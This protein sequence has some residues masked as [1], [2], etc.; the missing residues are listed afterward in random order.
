MVN[1]L[2]APNNRDGDSRELFFRKK[3]AMVFNLF[4]CCETFIIPIY[5]D[6]DFMKSASIFNIN[7]VR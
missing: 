2:C 5:I 6:I 1:A 7:L 4:L 3:T